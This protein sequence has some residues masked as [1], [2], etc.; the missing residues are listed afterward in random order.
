MQ[1]TAKDHIPNIILEAK[2]DAGL[3]DI[4]QGIDLGRIDPLVKQAFIVSLKYSCVKY[5]EFLLG[6]KN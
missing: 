2:K 5:A 4:M 3:A 1:N 6:I